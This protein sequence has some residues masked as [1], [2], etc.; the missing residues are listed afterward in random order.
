MY[1]DSTFI[2]NISEQADCSEINPYLDK[3]TLKSSGD[4]KNITG[5][6][7]LYVA[8]EVPY[9][10]FTPL[11]NRDAHLGYLVLSSHKVLHCLPIHR[12]YLL[13]V[14]CFLLQ[15]KHIQKTHTLRYCKYLGVSRP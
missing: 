6:S 2:F 5:S 1:S 4:H 15:K 9:P 3:Q 12:G 8:Y 10:W 14:R 13:D 11:L 7:L